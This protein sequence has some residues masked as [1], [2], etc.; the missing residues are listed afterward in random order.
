MRKVAMWVVML[1]SM[2]CS[3]VLADQV[4]LKNGDRLTGAII[5][6]DGEN[7]IF[8]SEFAGEVKIQWDAVE[9]I[10]S[11]SPLYCSSDQQRNRQP[12][13]LSWPGSA[14]RFG[15]ARR[16]PGSARRAATP[17]RSSSVSGRRWRAP[18]RETN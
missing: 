10:T 16:T 17:T 15:A 13:K 14:G 4:S 2:L 7:L 8:K 1:G 9:K 18:R 5:K 6:Y 12:M 3:E 11:D